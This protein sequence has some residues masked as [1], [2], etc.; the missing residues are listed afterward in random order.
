MIEGYVNGSKETEKPKLPRGAKFA[1][2]LMAAGLLLAPA[3]TS[4][5]E[6]DQPSPRGAETSI[7]KDS[8]SG[9]FSDNLPIELKKA[10][11]Y[12]VGS[13]AIGDD[14]SLLGAFT[15]TKYV[16]GE[17]KKRR[18]DVTDVKRLRDTGMDGKGLYMA[19]IG[20]LFI[21]DLVNPAVI[22]GLSNAV[23]L[24]LPDEQERLANNLV[25]SNLEFSG[26]STS[27]SKL[28]YAMAITEARMNLE[29]EVC[30]PVRATP[31]TPSRLQ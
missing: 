12:Y 27:S 31:T 18:T 8:E 10:C 17:L 30:P 21:G 13:K 15:A 22:L 7:V 9:I 16:E 4:E 20:Q 29:Q 25:R 6:K 3:C 24:G 1:G 14:S 2:A 28:N 23:Q 26:S 5:E 19:S 11:E